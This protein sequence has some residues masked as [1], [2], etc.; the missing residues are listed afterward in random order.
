MAFKKDVHR[1]DE[2]CN[3]L[4]RAFALYFYRGVKSISDSKF[5]Q[6]SSK[7]IF[8][9]TA[10]KNPDKVNVTFVNRDGIFPLFFQSMGKAHDSK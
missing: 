7:Y 8:S 3:Y 1:L 9:D 6:E 10:L 4:Q 2:N 5:D